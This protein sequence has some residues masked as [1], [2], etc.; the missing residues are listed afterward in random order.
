MVTF[1]ISLLLFSFVISNLWTRICV[2]LMSFLVAA[3]VVWC[4][5]TAFE[6]TSGGEVWL[7]GLQPSITRAL[8][9]THNSHRGPVARLRDFARGI[10]KSLRDSFGPGSHAPRDIGSVHPSTSHQSVGGV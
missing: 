8:H 9:H 2:T 10:V 7:D 4:I 1:F 5:W 6:S 3:L